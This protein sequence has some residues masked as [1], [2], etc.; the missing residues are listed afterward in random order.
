MLSGLVAVVTIWL[1]R[2]QRL[3]VKPFGLRIDRGHKMIPTSTERL[4]AIGVAA[5]RWD[6]DVLG[7]FS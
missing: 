7:R 5:H 6:I 1:L 3:L 4:S 2:V